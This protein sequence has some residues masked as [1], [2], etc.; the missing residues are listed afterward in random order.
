M[1][2][3]LILI[4]LVLL[5]TI[6]SFLFY[7]LL[8]DTLLVKEPD[9]KIDTT[10]RFINQIINER[11]LL[12]HPDTLLVMNYIRNETLFQCDLSSFNQTLYNQVGPILSD[13]NLHLHTLNSIPYEV[14]FKPVVQILI[15]NEKIIFYGLFIFNT[16][17][18]IGLILLLLLNKIYSMI[19]ICSLKA[20]RNKNNRTISVHYSNGTTIP[21]TFNNNNNADEH[22][23]EGEDQDKS[24]IPPNV[25][26][27][28]KPVR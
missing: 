15:G 22:Q 19:D 20:R 27:I 28:R 12:C 18:L 7:K 3:V 26:R 11:K 8:Y 4:L 24:T 17:F 2:H 10:K 6:P 14:W 25:L 23:I 21:V 5:I 1:I 16:G 9:L 13:E